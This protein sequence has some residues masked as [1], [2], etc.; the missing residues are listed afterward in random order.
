MFQT[1]AQRS[2]MEWSEENLPMRAAFRMLLEH[3][4]S[5][6][7]GRLPKDKPPQREHRTSGA[8]NNLRTDDRNQSP[9]RA[10]WKDQMRQR[11]MRSRCACGLTPPRLSG[12]GVQRA[13]L[14]FG[15]FSPRPFAIPYKHGVTTNCE[16]LNAITNVHGVFDFQNRHLFMTL[17][18]EGD[19]AVFDLV[20]GKHYALGL[21]ES[22]GTVT[23]DCRTGGQVTAL[24]S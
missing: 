12:S 9:P 22:C 21:M 5:A 19:G 23:A 2:R 6:G 20:P 4:Q 10:I 14:Q 8:P 18:L 1:L 3:C 13:N 11:K 17:C 16:L 7:P 15:E 24:C